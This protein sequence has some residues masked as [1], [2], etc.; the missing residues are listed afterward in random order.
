VKKH[1]SVSQTDTRTDGRTDGRHTVASRGKN[2]ALSANECRQKQKR[3]ETI[4]GVEDIDRRRDVRARYA[5]NETDTIAGHSD[6]VA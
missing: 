3:T 4:T 1:A 6:K 5:Y 2:L